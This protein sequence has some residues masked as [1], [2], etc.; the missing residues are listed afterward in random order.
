MILIWESASKQ[1]ISFREILLLKK[2]EKLK[3]IRNFSGGARIQEFPTSAFPPYNGTERSI[4]TH[5]WLD[6]YGSVVLPCTAEVRLILPLGQ[7][8]PTIHTDRLV[9][10]DSECD[11]I[12]WVITLLFAELKSWWG[13]KYAVH[14]WSMY[15]HTNQWAF[16]LSL[17]VDM[18]LKKAVL[19]QIYPIN[20]ISECSE[21]TTLE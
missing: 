13:D 9:A 19:V 5:L 18:N 4:S 17:T 1:R 11:I 20:A 8:S 14:V 10:C 21:M 7:D 6:F 3:R 12:P 15:Y 16:N 2:A